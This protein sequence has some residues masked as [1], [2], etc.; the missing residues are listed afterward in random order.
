[1]DN[2]KNASREAHAA[3]LQ[4]VDLLRNYLGE[5][6]A[7]RRGVGADELLGQLADSMWVATLPPGATVISQGDRGNNFFV[8]VSGRCKGTIAD[9]SSSAAEA[10]SFELGPG[11][12]FGEL[13]L[14]TGEPRA[15]TVVAVD[16]TTLLVATRR[17]FLQQ[18]GEA[19]RAKR[20]Q[21]EKLFADVFS[22]LPE[23]KP[24]DHMLLADAVVE[25]SY[26]RT[27]AVCAAGDGESELGHSLVIVKEGVLR[28]REAR[29][30]GKFTRGYAFDFLHRAP[31]DALVS[32]AADTV[33]GIIPN[34]VFVLFGKGSY[35]CP[36]T[37]L[38][39][40]CRSASAFISA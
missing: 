26:A 3:A 35:T 6:E 39:R 13:A 23:L 8:V 9:P 25:R 4:K 17:I 15:A 22:A 30:G 29:G 19:V 32:A 14:L 12:S 36:A 10:P 37:M 24:Y 2:I 16:E 1:M 34:K 18:L 31:D 5:E 11:K 40:L 21:W 28:R 38:Q 27:D 33:L 7:R 20:L